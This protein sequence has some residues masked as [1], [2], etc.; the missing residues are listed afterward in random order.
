MGSIQL[1]YTTCH[2][3][4]YSNYW[5]AW[6]DG[7]PRYP[8]QSRAFDYSQLLLSK[9]NQR[10]SCCRRLCTGNRCVLWSWN[11]SA[12]TI[13]VPVLRWLFIYLFL[14]WKQRN[15]NHQ[16]LLEA[17]HSVS[18]REGVRNKAATVCPCVSSTVKWKQQLPSFLRRILELKKKHGTGDILWPAL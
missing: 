7:N 6:H 1:A 16:D 8:Q 5:K 17:N 11:S 13:L 3:F 18:S 10:E 4:C 14:W 15:I 2:L 9:V 12:W